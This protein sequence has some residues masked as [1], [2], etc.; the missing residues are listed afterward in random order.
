[1]TIVSFGALT[2]CLFVHAS[3]VKHFLWDRRSSNWVRHLLAPAIGFWVVAVVIW[4]MSDNAKI[5][6]GCWMAVG[7]AVAMVQ[8]VRRPARS[9]Q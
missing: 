7:L 5:M 6:G 2:A 4:G 8:Y 1:V 3:V 9:A